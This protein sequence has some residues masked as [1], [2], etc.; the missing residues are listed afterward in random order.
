MSSSPH[1][2]KCGLPGINGIPYGIHMCHFYESAGDLAA[3]LVP[4]FAAG[5]RNNER[6]TWIAAEPLGAVL[7]KIAAQNAGLDVETEIRKGSLKILDH[8]DW[9]SAAGNLKGDELVQVWLDEERRA[10]AEGYSGLRI[11]GNTTFVT[12]E[13]WDDFMDYEHAVSG[14]LQGRRI[15]S[16]C[17]YRLGQVGA[18][19]LLDVSRRHHCTLDRPDQGWQI[20]TSGLSLT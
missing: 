11:T 16:L 12:P 13:A 20:L 19:E 5:L 9:Y 8:A 18:S 6:C 4:Y 10:L 3:A 2:T 14:A 15:V 17:S 7:A 1:F